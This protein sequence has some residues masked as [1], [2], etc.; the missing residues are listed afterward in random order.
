M[1]SDASTE[2]LN[3]RSNGEIISSLNFRPNFV[4]KGEKLIPFEEDNWKWIK[5]GET[6]FRNISPCT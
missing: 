3:T 5:I 2:Y 1:I 6:V 4:V